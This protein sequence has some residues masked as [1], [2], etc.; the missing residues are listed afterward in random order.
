MCE[1]CESHTTQHRKEA[2][3]AEYTNNIDAVLTISLLYEYTGSNL[4]G[5]YSNSVD[6][7]NI[8]NQKPHG[9]NGFIFP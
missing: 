2:M 1:L 5:F 8:R 7:A 3:W 4:R 9:G 6:K